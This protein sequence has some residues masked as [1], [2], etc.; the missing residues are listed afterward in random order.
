[1]CIRVA[2]RTRLNG[3]LRKRYENYKRV[4]H[5]LRKD[6]NYQ[7]IMKVKSDGSS[8]AQRPRRNVEVVTQSEPNVLVHEPQTMRIFRASLYI[9]TTDV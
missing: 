5:V 4:S 9:N 7:G 2:C 8:H 6:I 1:V 3:R